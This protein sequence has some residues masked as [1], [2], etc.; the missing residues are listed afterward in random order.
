M[1]YVFSQESEPGLCDDE[2]LWDLRSG[3][4]GDASDETVSSSEYGPELWRTA[5]AS[6]I[7]DYDTSKPLFV[8]Y[9]ESLVHEPLQVG[10]IFYPLFHFCRHSLTFLHCLLN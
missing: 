1:Y 10:L 2:C 3:S 8:Y 7:S 6:L 4:E 5:F 9:A